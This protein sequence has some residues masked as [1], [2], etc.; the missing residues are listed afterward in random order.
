MKKIHIIIT[1]FL[2]A[3][4]FSCTD[5]SKY[6]VPFTELNNSNA[7]TLKI[8]GVNSV[9]LTSDIANSKYETTFE[10]ND[11]D[12]GALFASADLYVS[13]TDLTPL[14]G[15]TNRAEALL[16]SY[17][18]SE[19]TADPITGLPRVTMTH[20][21]NEVMTLLGITLPEIVNGKDQFKFR[22][23]MVF[24]DGKTYTSS[25]VNNAIAATGGVYKSPFENV[26]TVVVCASD[27]GGDVDYV[28]IVTGA[29]VPIAPCLP[30]VSGTTT[31]TKTT[32][33]EYALGDATFGQYDCAWGDTPAAGVNWVDFCDDIT[34]TGADKYGLVYGFSVV[35]NDGT[36]LV[37]DWYNDYG[38]TGTSS[39]TRVGGAAWPLALNFL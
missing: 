6:P 30:S 32:H 18:P 7:G 1:L 15:G 3:L 27:L 4:G 10:A 35:T 17:A 19:F 29:V 21:A 8:I 13:F 37:V 9:F 31:F 23:A 20:T 14:N 5:E 38:D 36:T 12:R 39:L 28:T 24:P 33:G 11:R 26:I 2:M 34:V 16:K 22:Q 25:N